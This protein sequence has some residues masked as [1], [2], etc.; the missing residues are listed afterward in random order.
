MLNPTSQPAAPSRE[1]A[2]GTGLP[3]DRL[4]GGTR[5]WRDSDDLRRSVA[6][7]PCPRSPCIRRRVV[8]N[9]GHGFFRDRMATAKAIN[10]P[11]A[12]CRRALSSTSRELPTGGP[13]PSEVTAGASAPRPCRQPLLPPG[14]P[15]S[16]LVNTSTTPK[17]SQL[18]ELRRDLY[19]TT[20]VPLTPRELH[21]QLR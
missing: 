19:R 6:I 18:A 12:P 7:S 3:S 14:S 5:T 20:A 17:P 16:E 8:F 9:K 10:P 4:D 15:T 13:V 1:A 21:C 2:L 11:G